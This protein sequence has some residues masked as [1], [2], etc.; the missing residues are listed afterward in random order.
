[1]SVAAASV[2]LLGCRACGLLNRVPTTPGARACTR[3]GSVLHAR[4]PDSLRRTWALLIAA[5]LLYLPANLMPI[6]ETGSLGG[7]EPDTIMSGAIKLWAGGWWP[8]AVVILIASIVIPLVKLTA[9]AYLLQ[10]VR[11]GSSVHR[12]DRARL[13]RLI[14]MVGKWSMV[15]IYVGALL[16]GLVQ[17]PPLATTAPGPGAVAFGAVV[18]LTMFASQSFDP[19]LLWDD[20]VSGR[21][22]HG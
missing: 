13:Y 6:I 21:A 9:L 16:V 18:V 2:G 5:Y 14:G 11:D 12:R 19:R 10:T 7:E 20:G 4:K 3:C 17:F 8:L 15:E 22:R 1:M